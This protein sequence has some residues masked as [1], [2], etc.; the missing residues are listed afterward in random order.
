LSQPQVITDAKLIEQF[1]KKAMEEPEVQI[2]TR[3]PSESEVKLPGGFI[4]K[5]GELVTTAEVRELTG[6]DE[7]AIAKAGTI[8]KS[9]NVLLQRG[10]MSLGSEEV[11]KDD[12]DT[13]LSGDRDAILIGVRRVTFGN[14]ISIPVQCRSCRQEDNATIDLV[15]D[16]PERKLDDP[17][18]DRSWMVETTRG[19][20]RVVLPNGVVQK[21]LMENMDKTSAEINTLLLSGCIVSIDGSPSV[22]ASTALSLSMADRAKIIDQILDRNPGPR[23]GEVTKVCKAC[24]ETMELPLSLVDLFRL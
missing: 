15:A 17:I 18:Q 9:L 11:S 6:A 16:V 20:V 21:K 23:L 2:K 14:T 7:E 22:G 24:G 13:L 1:A 4:N 5:A 3:A 8:G 19:V 10:L 12:L